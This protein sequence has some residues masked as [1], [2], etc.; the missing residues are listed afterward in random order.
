MYPISTVASMIHSNPVPYLGTILE[1]SAE[2]VTR[3]SNNTPIKKGLRY[4]RNIAPINNTRNKIMSI[5]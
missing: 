1:Q 5:P 3:M 4:R 2:R